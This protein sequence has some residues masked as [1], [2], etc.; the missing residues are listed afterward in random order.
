MTLNRASKNSYYL[1]YYSGDRTHPRLRWGEDIITIYVGTAQRKYLV[2]KAVLC[3]NSRF[4]AAA[5]N[6]SNLKEGAE[7][8]MHLPEDN[9]DAFDQFTAWIY[10]G[11]SGLT[12]A[13]EDKGLMENL[14]FFV[15][16]NK[17]CCV[18]VQRYVFGNIFNYYCEDGKTAVLYWKKGRLSLFE[19]FPDLLMDLMHHAGTDFEDLT[20]EDAY[21]AQTEGSWASLTW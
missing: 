5:F 4:F 10:G 1:R 8:V 7:Q 15:L 11:H 2:H 9:V 19:Q 13:L 3:A 20:F 21:K 17:F 18:P 14:Q 6:N 16:A 12:V